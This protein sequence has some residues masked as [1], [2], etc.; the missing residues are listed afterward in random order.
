MLSTFEILSFAAV[1]V[2]VLPAVL[3]SLVTGSGVPESSWFAKYYRAERFLNLAGN[4]FL[5]TVCAYAIARLGVHFGY[6]D[7]SV[8][9]RL[10]LATGWAFGVTLLAYLGLWIRAALKV[11]RS[12]GTHA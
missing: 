11:H 6:I 2:L 3:Y 5:L 4:V 12:S 8:S 9:D 10:M 1:L 7:A